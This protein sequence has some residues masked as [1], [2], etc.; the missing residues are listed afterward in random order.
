MGRGFGRC[1]SELFP[2]SQGKGEIK[3]NSRVLALFFIVGVVTHMA[4]EGT[5][6]SGSDN[7]EEDAAADSEVSLHRVKRQWKKG[8]GFTTGP[9][10]ID[11]YPVSTTP[12]MMWGG[13]GGK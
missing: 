7:K 10:I 3:M 6:L 11:E 12:S 5:K 2:L 8:F 1:V 13:F 4:V 9:P